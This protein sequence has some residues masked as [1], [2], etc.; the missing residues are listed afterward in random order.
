MT[1][2]LVYAKDRRETPEYRASLH[3]DDDILELQDKDIRNLDDFDPIALYSWFGIAFCYAGLGF[4]ALS[5]WSFVAC[6][7]VGLVFFSFALAYP[8]PGVG[9][10][11]SRRNED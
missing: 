5:I 1:L 7:A 8:G 11:R 3:P 2:Y 10:G 6:V 9:E 4:L